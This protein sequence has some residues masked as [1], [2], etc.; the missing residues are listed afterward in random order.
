MDTHKSDNLQSLDLSLSP[1]IFLD[2]EEKVRASFVFQKGGK[3]KK[4]AKNQILFAKGKCHFK[5]NLAKELV[6]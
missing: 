1:D 5:K 2:G 6:K 3:S 4:K